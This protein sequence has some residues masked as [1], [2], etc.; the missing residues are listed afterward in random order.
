MR[1]KLVGVTYIVVGAAMTAICLS[2]VFD[3]VARQAV[4]STDEAA[5]QQLLNDQV[6]AWNRGDLDAF[7][8]GYQRGNDVTFFAN[9]AVHQGWEANRQRYRAGH[10]E[11]GKLS[12]TA[13]KTELVGPDAACVQGRFYLAKAKTVEQGLFTL[14]LRRTLAGWRIVHDHTSTGVPAS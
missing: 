6:A 2:M 12:F 3:V 11:M 14:V 9:D 13:L 1:E 8:E 10:T 7:M 5:I 4:A